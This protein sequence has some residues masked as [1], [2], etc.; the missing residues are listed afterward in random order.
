MTLTQGQFEKT[1]PSVWQ[2]V[3][4]RVENSGFPCMPSPSFAKEISCFS[5][6]HFSCINERS[7]ETGVVDAQ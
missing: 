3:H 2:M 7:P 1:G 5:P 6:T 4:K